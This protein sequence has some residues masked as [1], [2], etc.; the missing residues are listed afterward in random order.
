[1]ARSSLSL[2]VTWQGRTYPLRISQYATVVSVKVLLEELTEV[3]VESQKLL[4]LVKGRLPADSSTLSE[5]SVADG[6][7]VRLMGT[8]A[9]DKLRARRAEEVVVEE[10]YVPDR[11]SRVVSTDHGEK[12]TNLVLTAEV[13]VMN[14][15]RAGRR[16]VVLDLDYTLFD[17]KNVS[18]DIA[19]MA[20]P[21]LHEFLAAI[22]PFYDIVIWSQTKWFVV[23][24]KITLLGML[25]NPLYRVTAALDIS[26]MFSVTAVRNGR[27]VVHQVKPLEFIWRRLPMYHAGN[28]VHVDDVSRNFALNPQ[29]GLKIHA[30]KR[31]DRRPRR[32]R[33][34]FA[35]AEYLVRIAQLDSFEELDHSKWKTYRG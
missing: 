28:T 17:C 2:V 24:S 9:A 33:E 22:Y 1:M 34:L 5:L 21:G 16:L 18:G 27:T 20:R 6:T 23:E 19:D 30:F 31:A 7:R 11:S 15:P 10:D 14:A 29:N 8:R 3:E 35:L 4:G 12:L 32:D 26:T 13:R 25:A